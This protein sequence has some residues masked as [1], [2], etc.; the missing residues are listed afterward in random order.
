MRKIASII[1]H[2]LT[3]VQPRALKSEFELRFGDELVGKL[4]F[5]KFLSSLAEAETADGQWTFQRVGFW[6]K[7]TVVRASG[8]DADLATYVPNVWKGG[9]TLEVEGGSKY[10]LEV[11]RWRSTVEFKTVAGETLVHI[12]IRGVFR[13]SASVQMYRRALQV[14]ELPLMLPLGL[15]LFVMMQRDSAAHAAASG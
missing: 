4:H 7:R 9:G 10:L 8:A 13:H 14:A 5:P 15:Y 12:K 1:D 3:W 6:K 11:N 2:E